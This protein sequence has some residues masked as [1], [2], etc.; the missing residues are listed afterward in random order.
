MARKL[1]CLVLI[2]QVVSLPVT[3]YGRTSLYGGA[4]MNPIGAHV[5]PTAADVRTSTGISSV[6][7]VSESRSVIHQ[8]QS[9]AVIDWNSFNIGRDASVHFD[10]QKNSSW[11]ALNRIHDA[12]PSQILGTLTADGKVYLINQNGILF[13]AG[14]QVNVHSLVASSLNIS[15]S[16]FEAGLDRFRAENYQGLADWSFE[17]AAVS[18]QGVIRTDD[19]GSVYLLGANVENLGTIVT[20][21]GQIGLAAGS[22]IDL[23]AGSTQTNVQVGS[24]VGAAFNLEG[25][26]LIA[27]TGVVGMYGR[28]VYQEG[29]IRAVSA[30]RKNG[31]IELCASDRIVTGIGSQTLVPISDSDETVSRSFLTASTKEV[32][33]GGLDSTDANSATKVIEHYGEIVAP[34]GSVT[35]SA[36]EEILLGSQSRIDVSGLWVE[37]P[38]SA[39]SVEVT[40]N[41]VELR[42]DYGQKG[43]L[44]QGEEITVNPLLGS[45]VGD[46]SGYLKAE[47]VTAREAATAG[48]TI[49]LKV[50]RTSGASELAVMKGAE[51]AFSGGGIKYLGGS[52]AASTK[53][54]SGNVIYD[55]SELPEY[56][57]VDE[58]L[59]VYTK[60]HRRYGITE[61]LEGV[62]GGGAN[63]LLSR[64]DAWIQGDDAGQLTLIASQIL[65]NGTLYGAA[66]AGYYQILDHEMTDE[67]GN[68]A[69]VGWKRPEAGTLVIGKTVPAEND[70]LGRDQVVE[71]IV[72]PADAVEV[73]EDFSVADDIPGDES[74]IAAGVLNDSGVGNVYLNATRTVRTTADADVRLPAGGLLSVET[75]EIV[76]LGD[77]SIPSGTIRFVTDENLT[78]VTSNSRYVEL[79]SRIFLGQ[80]S[81]LSVAGE[82]VIHSLTEEGLLHPEGSAQ[83][84]GGAIVLEDRSDSGTGVVA[85]QGSLLDVSGGYEVESGGAVTGGDAGSLQMQGRALVLDGKLKGEALPGHDGGEIVLHAQNV[86]VAREGLAALVDFDENSTLP[87][88]YIDRLVLDDDR[89]DATGFTRIALQSADNLT[90]EAGTA[91]A[92]SRV[93]LQAAAAASD[94]LKGDYVDAGL[95]LTADGQISPDY[96]GATALSV[97]AGVPLDLTTPKITLPVNENAV[98]SV[99]AGAVLRT[100]PEGEISLFGPRVELAGTLDAP[101]GEIS[102]TGQYGLKV[103][104]IALV[105]ARGYNKPGTEAAADYLSPNAEPLDGGSVT[106]KAPDGLLTVEAGAVVDVSAAAPVTN[107]VL[108]AFGRPREIRVSGAPGSIT[109]VSE[110]D[111]VLEGTFRAASGMKGVAGGAFSLTRESLASALQVSDTFLQRLGDNGFDDVTLSSFH[112]LLFDGDCSLDLGRRLTLDT[113]EISLTDGSDVTLGANWVTVQNTTDYWAAV[114]TSYEENGGRLTL[115]GDWIDVAGRVAVSGVRESRWLAARDLRLSEFNYSN[116][117]TGNA[118][119]WSGALLTGGDLVLQAQ[120][121]YPTTLSEFEIDSLGTITILPAAG[122]SGQPIYSA[123]GILSLTA[124]KGIRHYGVVAAPFG[125]LSLEVTDEGG[126]VLLGEGSLLSVQGE[127]L[128]SYGTVDE[129]SFWVR[130]GRSI[131]DPTDIETVPEKGITVEAD[132]IEVREGAVVDVSGGGTLFGLAFAAGISGSEN[133]LTKDGRYVVVPGIEIP[134]RA[135]YLE[136]GGGIAAGVYSILPEEFAFLPGAKVIE[137]IG[138]GAVAPKGGQLT[139]EGYSMVQGYLTELGSCIRSER[140]Q[141]F[142]IRSARD[143]LQEGSFT[144]Y[145]FEA[146]HGGDL[147]LLG[148][149]TLI[150]GT[151]KGAGLPGFD[152]GTLSLSGTHVRVTDRLKPEEGREGY[153]VIGEEALSGAGFENIWLGDEATQTLT[154]TTGATVSGEAVTLEAGRI[155]LEGDSTVAGLSEDG[156]GVVTLV[157]AGDGGTIHLQE[158]ALVHAS[159]EVVIDTR[160]FPTLEG[161]IVVD[162]GPLTLVSDAIRFVAEGTGYAGTGLDL[163]AAQ[164]NSLSGYSSLKLLSRGAI[165][166]LTD[167]ALSTRDS[168]AL[169]AALI[170]NDGVLVS[171]SADSVTLRN[172]LGTDPGTVIAD[173]SGTLTVTAEEIRLGAGEVRLDGFAQTELNAQGDV[174]VEGEG[175]LSGGGDLTISSARVTAAPAVEADGDTA[176]ADY[177]ISFSGA[178]ALVSSGGDIGASDYVGGAFGLTGDTVDMNGVIDMVGGRVTLEATA[179]DVLIGAAGLIS[180]AGDDTFAGGRIALTSETGVV[181]VSAGS[182]LD[183][184]A[185]SQG[186]AGAIAVTS[187]GGEAQLD[188]E[189]RGASG[190]GGTGASFERDASGLSDFGAL[191]AQLVQGGFNESIA[192]R[193]R[194]GSLAVGAGDEVMARTIE[195]TADQGGITV[196]GTLNADSA[197]YEGAIE[198]QARDDILLA[199]GS[200]L[201]A[202]GLAA[203]IG[204]GEIR[205][206]SSEGWVRQEAGSR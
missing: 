62:Y 177:A 75:R 3:G 151:L 164:W 27:D 146:G 66:T 159:D 63:A 127:S 44:L 154:V 22:E 23:E 123:G 94:L 182:V 165:E 88:A 107:W 142:S 190:D 52:A 173:D 194:N 58:I 138:D 115:Q 167:F 174:I 137:L 128:V 92:P 187:L 4:V 153:L 103:Y 179:G 108:D 124:A 60:Y 141:V 77:I 199:A 10:Q 160:H 197:S 136:G 18:N 78:S 206:S 185:G 13:G 181:A 168:L 93:R 96:I 202:D 144:T 80:N 76:H 85:I 8:T 45:A 11:A 49:E 7:E 71:K 111:P 79:Q 134:G 9:R 95:Y 125:Q 35:F 24:A 109:L 43:G 19:L 110:Y 171:L 162:D 139:E 64:S 14:S 40:L 157:A 65:L 126:E 42:D 98:L 73:A 72:V 189:L 116:L 131:N 87:E 102:V 2:A 129:N 30:V 117:G 47:E 91:L 149:T 203:G 205:L 31:R 26:S 140:M 172:S 5:H 180:V 135:V 191:A 55:I 104:D 130:R 83:V 82:R 21:V 61:T 101:A 51:I 170:G 120:R 89:L 121:I 163:T 106:L 12:N 15:T 148:S 112:A 68:Q 152:G 100:A 184:S 74:V 132:R 196:A 33:F 155:D 29:L 105:L 198:L 114:P 193:V 175:R 145:S 36:G 48:G 57:T 169:D 158:G 183:V 133:P 59:G 188:G 90:V 17:R 70:P 204:G 201:S 32:F 6:E 186:D 97:A 50:N 156:H 39:A 38:A 37:K 69:T 147:A 118:T 46:I 119:G 122:A 81:S 28:E 34:S 195:L 161:E 99:E 20:P 56:A 176:A 84:N 113:P 1:F 166:F 86:T 200:E 41:S 67:Y 143:V 150:E 54:R 178:A 25:G 192:I 16:D 53:V